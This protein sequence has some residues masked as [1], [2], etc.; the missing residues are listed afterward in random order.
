MARILVLYATPSDPAAFDQHYHDIHIPL[1]KKL[2]G[3]Q[4][5]D[6]STGPINSPAGPSPF[7]AIATLTFPD[8]PTLQSALASSEG[9]AAAADAQTLMAPG[10]QLLIFDTH[11]A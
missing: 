7:H 5:F 2:P 3:L 11:K 9:Q 4:A 8:M 10:S 6:L 1:A